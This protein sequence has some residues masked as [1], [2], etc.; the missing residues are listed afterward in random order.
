M[1]LKTSAVLRTGVVSCCVV[2]VAIVVKYRSTPTEKEQNTL[3]IKVSIFTI[4]MSL[5]L[6]PLRGTP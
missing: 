4:Q 1:Y 2:R 5:I 3:H 6:K